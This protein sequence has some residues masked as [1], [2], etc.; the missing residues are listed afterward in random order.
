MRYVYTI[1]PSSVGALTLVASDNGLAG[2]L[3]AHENAARVPHLRE[4][5]KEK[6]HPLLE[7]TKRQLGEYFAKTR[8]RFDLPLDF[9]GSHFYRKVWAALLTIPYGQTRTYGEIARQVGTPA[10]ARAVGAAIGRNPI[11]IIA[12]CH[13]VIGANGRLTGFA[14]GLEMKAL[15]LELEAEA[16]AN[17]AIAA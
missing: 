12:P 3:W 6:N 15:L 17:N 11:S 2:I 9:I 8:H 1:T 16:M 10:A 4:M 13:R 7:E 14:G 5:S